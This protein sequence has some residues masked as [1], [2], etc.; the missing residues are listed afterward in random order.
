MLNVKSLG[1]QLMSSALFMN[2]SLGGLQGQM[3]KGSGGCQKIFEGI[4]CKWVVGL[5]CTRIT[6]L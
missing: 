5:L 6:V 2:I 4:M 3:G 1:P